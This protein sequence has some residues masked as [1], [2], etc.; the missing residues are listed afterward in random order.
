MPLDTHLQ[1]VTGSLQRAVVILR[2]VD[3]HPFEREGG[4]LLPNRLNNLTL[5]HLCACVEVI[6]KTLVDVPSEGQLTVLQHHP[7][8]TQTLHGRHVVAHEEHRT[9]LAPAHVLHLADGLL[10]K[11]RIAHGQHLIYHENLGFEVGG[12]GKAQSHHHAAGVAFHRRV[13]VFGHTGKIHYLVQFAANLSLGHAHDAAVHEDVLAPRHLG[14]EAR[15]HLQ[16]RGDTSLDA[17][18]SHSGRGDTRENLQQRALSRTVLADDTHHVALFHAE[19]DVPEGPHEPR[20]ATLR[21]VVGLADLEVGVI[22]A[23]EPCPPAVEVLAQRTRADGAQAVLLAHV[24]E[25]Y[26]FSAHDALLDYVHEVTLYLVENQDAQQE[27]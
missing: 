13:E 24:F 22:L 3:E 26:D 12:N 6:L 8:G 9:P 23:A 14:M 15:A 17:D 20:G 5:R 4:L 16:E 7:L 10:L 25:L 19:V 27:Y 18:A 11:L 21:A 1:R 2:T